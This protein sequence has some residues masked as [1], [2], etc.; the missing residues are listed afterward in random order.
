MVGCESVV[1]FLGVP[2]DM[3]LHSFCVGVWCVLVLWFS[4]S[5]PRTESAGGREESREVPAEEK[6]V[7]EVL[8][9]SFVRLSLCS[10]CDS[11]HKYKGHC[12]FLLIPKRYLYSCPEWS[13]FIAR[14]TIGARRFSPGRRCPSIRP[15]RSPEI[16]GR[17]LRWRSKGRAASVVVLRRRVVGRL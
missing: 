15:A 6:E 4:P 16:R 5:R 3:E 11:G 8:L 12:I 1:L 14:G 17:L 10:T 7:D 2:G 9:R 13:V